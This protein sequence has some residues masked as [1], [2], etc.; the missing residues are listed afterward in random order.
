MV[1]QTRL[2]ELAVGQRAVPTPSLALEAHR[3]SAPG[4]P[5]AS[6]GWPFVPVMAGPR[7]QAGHRG[8]RP[9]RRSSVAQLASRG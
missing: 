4:L 1:N 8:S 2:V 7:R 5:G 3:G 6:R 9:S